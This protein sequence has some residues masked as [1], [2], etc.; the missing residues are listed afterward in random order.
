VLTAYAIKNT[1]AEES[2][3]F[4]SQRGHQRLHCDLPYPGVVPARTPLDVARA[5]HVLLAPL[6]EERIALQVFDHRLQAEETI[7]IE[8]GEFLVFPAASCWH[9]GYGGKQGDR[10]YATFLIGELCD[11][12]RDCVLEDELDVLWWTDIKGIPD[13]DP[14]SWQAKRPHKSQSTG[15]RRVVDRK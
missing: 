3:L 15:A 6:N 12:Q 13:A 2:C 1:P 10:L 11:D 9:A 5:V 4:S 8:F 7:W 14:S